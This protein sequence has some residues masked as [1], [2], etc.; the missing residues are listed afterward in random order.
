MWQILS[1]YNLE[2]SS[3]ENTSTSCRK[4]LFLSLG[5]DHSIPPFSFCAYKYSLCYMDFPHLRVYKVTKT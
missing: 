3:E 2:A 4:H 5:S 1:C